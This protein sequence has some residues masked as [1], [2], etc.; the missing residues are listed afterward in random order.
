MLIV[1]LLRRDL[2]DLT[3]DEKVAISATFF[4]QE[5]KYVRI[6][7][8]DYMEHGV[9]HVDASRGQLLQLM[10]LRPEFTPYIAPKL[11]T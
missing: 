7:P 11:P 2:G 4:G 8:R 5:V 9:I 3:Y 10:P 1:A 6:D